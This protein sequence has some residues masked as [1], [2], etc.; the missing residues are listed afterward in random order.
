MTQ[1]QSPLAGLAPLAGLVLLAALPAA[2]QP[3][4]VVSS[5]PAPYAPLT[6]ATVVSVPCNP[7]AI[8]SDCMV[9]AG[10]GLS[11]KDEGYVSIPLGFDFPFFGALHQTVGVNSNGVLL[12]GAP[13]NDACNYQVPGVWILCTGDESAAPIPNPART[14]H[15]FIAPWW[16][17]AEGN[18]N[19]GIRYSRPNASE[20]VIEFQDWSQYQAN[21]GDSFQFQVRLNASGV[22]RIH[23]GSATGSFT[24]LAGFENETGTQ[25]RELID[26]SP[27]K[28]CDQSKWPSQTLFT[29]RPPPQPDLFVEA[30]SLSNIARAGNDLTFAVTAKFRNFGAAAANNFHWRAYLSLDKVKDAADL[31]VYDSAASGATVSVPG[32]GGTSNP[33]AT[34]TGTAKAINL[35]RGSYYVLVEADSTHLVAELSESNNVSA[36]LNP[37]IT[38]VDLLAGSIT[39]PLSAIAGEP[40]NVQ[41][42][43]SNQGTDAVAAVQYEIVLS[44]DGVLDA[45]DFVAH[46]ET[47]SVPGGTAISE[48]LTFQL[49][50]RAP[51][52]TVYWVLRIDPNNAVPEANENNNAVFSTA[53][54]TIEQADVEMASVDLV[55]PMTDQPVRTACF[56][57]PARV[58][59]SVRNIGGAAATGFAIGLALSADANLSL[60][61]DSLFFDS[62]PQTIPAHG[63]AEV[64]LDFTVPSAGLHGEPLAPGGYFLFAIADS[65]SS[66]TELSK[67]NNVLAVGPRQ[68]EQI[69]LRPPA[70]DYVVT[71]LRAPA[72]AAIGE[73]MP[74]FRSIKNI[75]SK[76]GGPIRYRFY[77]SA[78]EIITTEDVPLPIV[79]DGGVTSDTGEAALASGEMNERTELVLLPPTLVPGSWFI[80][81]VVDVTGAEDELAE[82][83]NGAAARA[84][85]LVEASSLRITTQSLP[86]GVVGAPYAFKLQLTGAQV[87]ATWSH[88]GDLPEGLTLT[89]DG[90]VSGTPT[91]AAAVSFTAVAAI[92]SMTANARLVI[93][94]LPPTSEL[95]I[96]SASL[97]AAV[98]GAH[99]LSD[100]AAAGGVRPY[101]WALLDGALPNGLALAP[102]GLL[103]GALAGDVTA[104]EYPLLV[105]VADALG[106]RA[107]AQLKIKV[108]DPGA[109][110]ITTLEVPEAL[111]EENYVADLA[112]GN[113]GGSPLATPLSWSLVGGRLPLGMMLTNAQDRRALIIGRPIESGTFPFTVQVVDAKGGADAVDLILRVHPRR[114][115]LSALNLPGAIHPGDVVSFQFS[116]AR[117]D[118]RFRVYSGTLPPGL[119]LD[120]GGTVSGT[121][122]AEN[123][124]GTWN[125][126]VQ[127]W[128]P[129]AGDALGPYSLEVTPS[130]ARA[131]GCTSV[132]GTGTGNIA[133]L[134][135]FAVV[136]LVLRGRRTVPA[137][138]MAFALSAAP[139]RVLAQAGATNVPYA[140][141]G[142][143]PAPYLPLAG[144]EPLQQISSIQAQTIALPFDFEFF[145][146][147]R[148][149]VS[150]TMFGYLEFENGSPWSVNAPI[151]HSSRFLPS[152]MIAPWWDD[153]STGASSAIAYQTEGTAPKRVFK[154]E[155]LNACNSAPFQPCL[156]TFSFRAELYEGS[157][158]IRFVY[159][160]GVPSNSAS[161]GV[162]GGLGLGV[163]A[164][165]CTTPVIGNCGI[166]S[167]PSNHFVE[168][169]A[170]PDLQLTGVSLDDT[171]YAGLPMPVV[172]RLSNSGALTAR[173]VRARFYLSTD[174]KLDALDIPLGDTEPLDIDGADEALASATLAIPTGTNP[175]EYLLLGKVDP[176]DAIAEGNEDDNLLPP[177]VVRVG[178]PTPDL[179]ITGISGPSTASKGAVLTVQ[180]TVQNAGNVPASQP[181]PITW[182]VS[183]NPV[184]TPS[185][186]EIGKGMIAGLAAGAADS[187]QVQVR[188]PEGLAA[189][190]YWIGACVDYDSLTPPPGVIPEIS[191]VNNCAT[192]N[193]F[194][195]NTGGLAIVTTSL[196]AASQ[197]APY[198]LVLE[199]VG[200]NGAYAWSLAGGTLPK[201]MALA[202]NG[203]LSGTPSEAGSFTFSASV[204]SAG[205]RVTQA[206]NLSVVPG[207]LPLA[208]VDQS[209]P[210][211]EFGRGYQVQLVAVGGRPPYVWSLQ[212]NSRLPEGLALS[213]DGFVEGRPTQVSDQPS[214]FAVEVTDSQGGSSA[215]ALQIR[216]VSPD[217]LHIATSRLAT[218]FLKREYR[219][220]LQATGGR[221][222]YQWSV[223]KFQRL[224]Q[225]ATDLPG[226]QQ[227]Q[228]PAGFGIALKAGA[229]ETALRGTPAM[230][231]LYALTLRVQDGEGNDDYTT[232]P[233][234]VSYEEALAITTTALP[235]AFAGQP[236]E[237][238]LS[239]NGGAGISVKFSSPCIWQASSTLSGIQYACVPT[240]PLHQ[241]PAGLTLAADGRISGT[242]AS[243]D[244][245]LPALFSFLVEVTETI[246]D[247]RGEPI[248]NGRSEVRS[249]SIKVRPVSGDQTGGC[250]GTEG[251]PDG[252]ALLVLAM[253]ARGRRARRVGNA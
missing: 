190:K 52:G 127:A 85:T 88:V 99:Y 179:L 185:D 174:S 239:H 235:D 233:L 219:Q 139:T 54:S 150:V 207:D 188:L 124:V 82:T 249:L 53:L 98:R 221:P 250:S 206:Y 196:P 212:K 244:L 234:L 102:E 2:A 17:D 10:G 155:W 72:S 95:F 133:C 192:G 66:L 103:S 38:G 251:G 253:L 231:G 29:I 136:A 132:P 91:V 143:L 165:P 183:E 76:N 131:A 36:A 162:M 177:L 211:A 1:L 208:I 142:P 223:L 227:N 241:L 75:G 108:V 40:V 20:I 11:V 129:L 12:F 247:A 202:A 18:A 62:S 220:A 49:P 246:P 229:N 175:G 166:F 169:G 57:T 87:P 163:A 182:F 51:G 31:L 19:G 81:A 134:L 172:A 70:A 110:L 104:G 125:F 97:P 195:L 114:L 100:L 47:R 197:S 164:L 107:R 7:P 201:G 25:G 120:E 4:Y 30:I 6:E 28:S 84:P 64:I 93:R 184:V 37:L 33:T 151:P 89:S 248:S 178:P 200:G 173:G 112:A 83:N 168:I 109:L 130:A 117:A 43:W 214:V 225:R 34:A 111:V 5:T 217:T 160:P 35:A 230:A 203:E 191:E 181:F 80:G 118:S 128:S 245:P 180:R 218:A 147:V 135:P 148:R 115:T 56:G 63:S 140:V 205:Q 3:S 216:V 94:V 8:A 46:S 113:A 243:P 116:T 69:E 90:V 77:A 170:P 226:S 144:A 158:K 204:V 78:N 74:V 58:K 41:V 138:G 194:T 48:Q 92:G 27:Q 237:A 67:Q 13:G 141:D 210:T 105:E 149:T 187:A 236:Y 22:F 26:C 106:N 39:A 186:V 159:G 32:T 45:D 232:L 209:L 121:V 61:S 73:V 252:F 157:N 152:V 21:N 171:G 198:G 119:H 228:L 50:P 55:D 16:T 213:G 65:F 161:V 123:S 153:I 146:L 193:A 240:E 79:V 42:N 86:D 137:L 71:K 242:P 126:V 9:N 24:G 224:A 44:A 68:M 154:V 176:D 189:G 96:S 60:L 14:P 59:A 199:A 145:G 156:Q 215:K 15:S 238:R 122:A 101:R 222:P 167:Y 23:Y